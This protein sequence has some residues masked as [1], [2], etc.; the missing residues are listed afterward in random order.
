M[1]K[2]A[3]LVNNDGYKK[4]TY[5]AAKKA[6]ASVPHLDRGEKIFKI[7]NAEPLNRY[8][9]LP[10]KSIWF[11]KV[12]DETKFQP[13]DE[14]FFI[15]Y[16]SF[17]MSYSRK[18]IKHYKKKYKNAKFYFFFTNPVG[19]YNS[20]RLR[21]IQDLLDAVYAFNKEDVK[22]Y[23]Y[24]FLE[25]E[26]FHLPHQEDLEPETDLFFIGADKG[27]LP[28][29]LSLYERMTSLGAICDFW[30]TEVPEEKQKYADSIHY[31]QRMSYEEVLR[32][33][34]KTRC[35]VEVL[36]EEKSYTSI[37]TM[38]AIQYHKKVLTMSES[39]KETCFYNP[40]II[41]VFHSAEDVSLDFIRQK[42]DEDQ[43]DLEDTC[44]FAYFEEFMVK[45]M[46]NTQRNSLDE[47]YREGVLKVIQSDLARL[48]NPTFMNGLKIY[49]MPRGTV[50]RFD[51]WF[52]VLQ[53]ARLSKIRR[54]TIGVIAYLIMRRYEYKYGI[55]ANA[56][57]YI[58]KGLH[59][60]HG[61]GV[62]LNCAYI[63]ENFTVYQ[64]VTLGAIHGELP[65]VLD[66]VT[67]YTNSVVGGGI[68]LHNGAI[69]GAQSYVD[70]DVEENCFVAGVPA[71]VL[72]KDDSNIKGE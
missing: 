20:R 8:I 66:N 35:I 49:L 64:G 16:E 48:C 5:E 6:G 25:A 57:I 27:R 61:D 50:F 15:L 12:V 39:V 54:I 9:E 60:K 33:D 29:L 17:H 31:N 26:P 28:I 53:W 43:F 19:E 52:R 38:E 46:G 1:S 13:D 37:R 30:I 34:A 7:H 42:I 24:R 44:S 63:G 47:L 65:V 51:V 72:N 68:T 3:F 14:I 55:H 67:V 21:K 69:V 23:G 36:Q 11:H 4:Y 71:R 70:K 2:F 18:L 58:G 56:N 10:L 45:S 32:H 41:Q 40:E 22:R 62:H 59:I